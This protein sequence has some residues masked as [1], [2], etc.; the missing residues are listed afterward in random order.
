MQGAKT[1]QGLLAEHQKQDGR[2]ERIEERGA[3]QPAKDGD[4]D[5]MQD[6]LARLA[7]PISSGTSA[8]PAASAVMRTGVM[9]SR[10]PRTTSSV[11]NAMPS[12]QA[13]D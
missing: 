9:R 2:D 12:L 8:T 4:R 3:D 7:A 13:Q 10:L 1:L 11:P 6:F 5:R